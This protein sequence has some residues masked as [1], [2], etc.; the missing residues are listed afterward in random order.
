MLSRRQVLLNDMGTNM[1]LE[2]QVERERRI[3]PEWLTATTVAHSGAK[4]KP[5]RTS[6][7]TFERDKAALEWQ[8]QAWKTA[9]STASVQLLRRKLYSNEGGPMSHEPEFFNDDSNF[10][11]AIQRALDLQKVAESDASVLKE[12]Q[13]E[14]S[15]ALLREHSEAIIKCLFHEEEECRQLA[16]DTIGVLPPGELLTDV[17]RPMLNLCRER[18]NKHLRV[19]AVRILS[20]MQPD[21]LMQHYSDELMEL[22]EESDHELRLE[23]Q[24]LLVRASPAALKPHTNKII[25]VCAHTRWYVRHAGLVVLSQLNF[26]ELIRNTTARNKIDQLCED[27][28]KFV[29]TAATSI[30]RRDYVERIDFEN[31]DE[32]ISKWGGVRGFYKAKSAM[33]TSA[34]EQP[35]ANRRISL[36]RTGSSSDKLTKDS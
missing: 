15:F 34:T 5:L 19:Y 14:G 24:E 30:V 28:N 27:D 7:S 32:A 26:D 6:Y 35:N 12:L 1:L 3:N 9:L 21:A 20:K 22:L 25:E 13:E 8:R 2:L 36:N 31:N 23:T 4:R 16:V 11:D 10:V 18:S 17:A 33:Q 29:K